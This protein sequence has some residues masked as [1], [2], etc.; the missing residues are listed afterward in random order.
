MT[1][2][3]DAAIL[4]ITITVNGRT[5]L[6]LWAPPWEDEEGEEWQGFLGD[7]AK[8]LLYPGTKELGEFIASGDENDLSDHPAWGYILKLTPDQLRPSSED[9]Y[10][11]DAVYEW[12]AGEPDPVSVSA[13]ANVV[14]MAAK[15][16]D[17]CDDGALRALVENTPAYA[18]LVD[19]DNSY[20]GK[21]GA[22]RWDEL[23]D[24]IAETWERAIG[25]VESWLKWEG[26]FSSSDLNNETIWDR[27]GARPIQIVYGDVTYL[28]LRA[29]VHQDTTDD[30]HA[31]FIGGDDTVAVFTQLADFAAYC[32]RAKDHALAKLEWWSEVAELEDDEVFTAE[33]SFDL[34]KPSEDGAD[35]V[36]ELAAFCDLDVDLSPLDATS[37]NK[38][39]WRDLVEAVTS[40][41]EPQD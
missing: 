26:D 1:S 37:V 16:A 18:E 3:A 27:I 21:D 24:L 8:I 32:R 40:C 22:K 19:E 25:R 34:R 35:L 17:C 11:L 33:E 9:H 6:T 5:G 4:P 10:D 29:Y 13:L 36:R 15:I 14:D 39:D 20:Q 31:V 41:L 30:R 12:A 7:G 28:T 23:G 2:S 38:D